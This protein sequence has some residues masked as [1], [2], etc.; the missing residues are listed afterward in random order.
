M[1]LIDKIKGKNILPIL[2]FFIVLLNY[3]PL[4]LNNFFTKE[5]KSVSTIFMII[6][7]TIEIVV[8]LCYIILNK[9]NINNIKKKTIYL[10]FIIFILFLVQIKNLIYNDF[11]I[12][13]IFN[14]GCIFINIGLFYI[15]ISELEINEK[16]ICSFYKGIVWIGIVAVIWNL[17]IYFR[18]I[19]GGL[20]FLNLNSM[21]E[22][23][24]IKSFFPN[25]N[26]FAFFL[27]IST[28]SN[29]FVINFDN[30]KKIYK[31][32]FIIFWFGVLCTHS[33]TGYL[34]IMLFLEIYIL[35]NNVYSIKKRIIVS[36]IIGIIGIIGIINIMGYLKF[37]NIENGIQI[38]K[39]NIQEL[40]AEK[41]NYS[42]TKNPSKPGTFIDEKKEIEESKPIVISK[43]RIQN[44]SG[45]KGIWEKGINILSNSI[46]NCIVGVGRFNSINILKFENR[47]YTQFHNIYLDMLLTGGIVLL[48]Y[49]CYIYYS[50]IKKI[51]KSKLK[52][53][54]KEIYIVMY[55]IYGIYILFE[56][57]GR[58]S[59]G[60]VDTLCLI[61]FVTIPL[62]HAN[63]IKNTEENKEK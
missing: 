13:D 25:R 9:I 15:I 53:I 20:G 33:K 40:K 4:F 38:M 58:F 59:I 36:M 45:R 57:C 3:L 52:L 21:I 16:S 60:A 47:T 31:Y 42:Q 44:L 11:Y 22:L 50:V 26:T 18:E 39:Q 5:S 37:P 34:L 46:I 63:S 29:A 2:L 43:E 23:E 6:C 56:S 54:F 61:F 14:I 8:F 51:I 30:D 7:F 17:I 10:L 27:F 12:M 41:D 24:G 28:I 1:K 49:I 19:L 48:A 32:A 62:L 35:L 55:I